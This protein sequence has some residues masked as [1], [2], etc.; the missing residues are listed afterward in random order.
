MNVEY[1]KDIIPGNI[2]DCKGYDLIDLFEE[3]PVT[4]KSIIKQNILSFI[5]DGLKSDLGPVVN[6]S[7]DYN[8]EYYY[9]L[10]YGEIVLEY[11]TGTS[12]MPFFTVKTVKE[13]LMLG[14]YLWKFRNEVKKIN[15]IDFFNFLHC[16]N[17][18]GY[19]FPFEEVGDYNELLI[20]ELRH[21]MRHKF[22]WWHINAELLNQYAN[23]INV[24]NLSFDDLKIDVIENNGAYISDEEKI[25]FSKLFN[26]NIVDNY[27]CRE[28]WCIG[29]DC[30]EGEMHVNEDCVYFELVNDQNEVIYKPNIIGK[31]LITSLRQKSMPYIRYDLGDIAYYLPGECKCGRKTKRIRVLPGR[32][33]IVGTNIYGNKLFREVMLHLTLERGISKFYS[34]NIMQVALYSFNVY[35]SGNQENSHLLESEF[36]SYARKKLNSREYN[37][38]FIYDEKVKLKSIFNISHLLKDTASFQ[39]K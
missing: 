27:G 26:C 20:L 10:S 23:A 9:N 31:V 28:L 33:M 19:P 30:I 2:Y 29:F 6:F 25:E 34:I 14:R 22:A 21:L 39:L 8:R 12:G 38:N 17:N 24:N 16:F 4:E 15:K 11:T 35:V 37:F 13:R 3:L 5:N 7:R 36:T 32:H 1:F 18:G